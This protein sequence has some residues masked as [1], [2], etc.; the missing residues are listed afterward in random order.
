MTSP[1]LAYVPAPGPNGWMPSLSPCSTVMSPGTTPSASAVICANVVAL[2]CPCG[3]MSVVRRTWP[4]APTSTDAALERAASPPVPPDPFV[5]S[6]MPSPTVRPSCRSRSRR[7][8]RSAY[9]ATSSARSSTGSKSPSTYGVPD[10]VVY[11]NWSGGMR[12]RRRRSTG[13]MP[14]SSPMRSRMRSMQNVAS[15]CPAPR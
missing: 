4:S 10:A 3:E 6:A 15:G 11:G 2:P 8:T 5:E 12:L 9:P 13:S 14:S 1:R 7:A